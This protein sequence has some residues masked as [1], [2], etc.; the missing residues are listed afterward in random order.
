MH[1][2]RQCFFTGD[3]NPSRGAAEE[4]REAAD[5]YFGILY[6]F[7][8]YTLHNYVIFAYGSVK[9]S[10]AL[11]T[12]VGFRNVEKEPLKFGLL[13]IQTLNEGRDAVGLTLESFLFP[14]L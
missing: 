9:K 5:Q 13:K 10:F 12:N 1:S 2:L 8:P 6:L 11:Q 4:C 7:F 3:N 14:V